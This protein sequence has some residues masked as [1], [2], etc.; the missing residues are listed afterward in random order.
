LDFIK[1][2]FQFR[3]LPILRW[4]ELSPFAISAPT[5]PRCPINRKSLGLSAS[6]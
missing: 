3:E 6:V 1:K 2:Y 5:A 4:R